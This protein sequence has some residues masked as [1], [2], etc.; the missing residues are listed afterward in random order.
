MLQLQIVLNTKVELITE[1]K[2]RV[3][4]ILQ[5]FRLNRLLRVSIYLSINIYIYIYIYIYIKTQSN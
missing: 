4:T 1:I 5:P 2:S 3:G